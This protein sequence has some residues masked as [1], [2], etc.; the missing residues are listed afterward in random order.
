METWLILVLF[1]AAA[2]TGQTILRKILASRK[3]IDLVLMSGL[4]PIV[5]GILLFAYAVLS[6]EFHLPNIHGI[7][8]NWILMV[9]LYASAGYL[10]NLA[11]RYADASEISPIMGSSTAWTVISTSLLLG[12]NLNLSKVIATV[13]IIT[14][15]FVLYDREG[16]F[17]WSKGHI[18]GAIAAMC[19]GLAFTN[20]AMI[21][22]QSS[23][24]VSYLPFAYLLPG[25]ATI[26]AKPKSLKNIKEI[27]KMSNLVVLLSFSALAA[28]GFFFKYAAYAGGG[29]VSTIAL[30]KKSNLIFSVI[31]C[32]I[33][34][35]ERSRIWNKII[36]TI[37]ILSGVIIVM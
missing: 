3:Q 5:A 33:F 26:L 12:E 15:I 31:V 25:V 9:F 13:L 4:F 14:G 20:D 27:G 32:Y 7:E 29:D 10:N 17:K 28:L 23:N 8:V 21:I 22:N 18:L 2:G 37:F 16:R 6:G 34:L 1:S 19:F 11:F 30:I 36:G 24:V 35:N